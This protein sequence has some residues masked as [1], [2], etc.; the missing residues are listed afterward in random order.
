MATASDS[1]S[2]VKDGKLYITP[3]LSADAIGYDNVMDG[4]TYNITG[5][6]NTITDSS[7]NKILNPDACGAVSNRTTGT[8]I[9]P[10]MSA[11]LNTKG[12]AAIT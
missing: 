10:I 2:Y 7:G 4:F 3:T 5:C 11:R 1:N 6:T 12:H 8:I 9:P